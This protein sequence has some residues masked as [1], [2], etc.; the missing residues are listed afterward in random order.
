MYFQRQIDVATVLDAYFSILLDYGSDQSDG[1][2]AILYT[3]LGNRQHLILCSTF[4]DSKSNPPI[5]STNILDTQ[6]LFQL[7][8]L[9]F[10][11][12]WS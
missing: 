7:Q 10:R 4:I 3:M 2:Q 5:F 6:S 1:A 9:N 8:F 12:D 11:A